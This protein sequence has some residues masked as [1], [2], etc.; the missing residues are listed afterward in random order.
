MIKRQARRWLY[1]IYVTFMWFNINIFDNFVWCDKNILKI[2]DIVIEKDPEC[3]ALREEIRRF[4]LPI[5]VVQ[6][7]KAFVGVRTT[8]LLVLKQIV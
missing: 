6:Y 1:L 3:S 7:N 2:V 5:S 8:F 4:L